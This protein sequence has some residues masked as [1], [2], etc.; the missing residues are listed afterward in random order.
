M[1]LD[2][3]SLDDR[4][5]RDL[6]A[7][8]GKPLGI[9]LLS[10]ASIRMGLTRLPEGINWKVMLGAGCLGGI[11]FTMSLFIAAQAFPEDSAFA[12]SKI[13]VFAASVIS[14]VAGVAILWNAGRPQ[15]AT[16]PVA[17]RATACDAEEP[18]AQNVS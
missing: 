15:E 13:A 2:G 11:G 4:V 5:V 8:V 1:V 14:A 3:V 9:V 7:V 12:A 6:A 17:A 18:G 10:W 16:S